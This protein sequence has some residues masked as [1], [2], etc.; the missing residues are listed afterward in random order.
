M[1]LSPRHAPALSRPPARRSA[2]A[3]MLTALVALSLFLSGCD[4]QM[5]RTQRGY[6][7]DNY[8]SRSYIFRM[9]Y[10]DGGTGYYLGIPPKSSVAEYGGSDPM[11]AVVYDVSCSRRLRPLPNQGA[12]CRL[13]ATASRLY[14]SR[15][16]HAGANFYLVPL[17]ERL[18]RRIP[19]RADD[20]RAGSASCPGFPQD[21]GIA[22]VTL[23]S[24]GRGSSR[25]HSAIRRWTSSTI[26]REIVKRDRG[27]GR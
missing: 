10:V 21:C 19:R 25:W 16:H 24:S 2:S 12:F 15:L 5:E 26:D 20:E 11:K 18:P 13:R 8:S 9:S 7:V 1:K 22:H 27:E 6:T 4:I 23:R 17:D 3:L 14:L